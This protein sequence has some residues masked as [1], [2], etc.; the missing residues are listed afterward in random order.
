MSGLISACLLAAADVRHVFVVWRLPWARR[1]VA[2]QTAEP[3][4]VSEPATGSRHRMRVPAPTVYP[5]EGVDMEPPNSSWFYGPKTIRPKVRRVV[6][7]G[8]LTTMR[9]PSSMP[10]VRNLVGVAASTP[11]ARRRGSSMYAHGS[12]AARSRSH[13]PTGRWSRALLEVGQMN[14]AV[15]CPNHVKNRPGC[16]GSG[17]EDD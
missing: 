2:G 12:A 1:E 5:R 6:L 16:D 11:Q 4:T 13:V 14:A 7:A 3:H 17:G 9:S 15:I 10:A 8:L